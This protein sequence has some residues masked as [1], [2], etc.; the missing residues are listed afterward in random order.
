[1]NMFQKI[2][3]L[4][5]RIVGCVIAILALFTPLYFSVLSYTG[6]TGPG[7]ALDVWTPSMIQFLVGALLVLASKPIGKFLGFGLDDDDQHPD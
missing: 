5:V 2:A 6:R 7:F 1:M 4:I 3:V